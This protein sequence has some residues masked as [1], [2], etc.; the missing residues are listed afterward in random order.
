M[1]WIFWLSLGLC[2]TSCTT[3]KLSALSAHYAHGPD[4]FQLKLRSREVMTTTGTGEHVLID[5]DQNSVISPDN[6]F[7][8]R[9]YNSH[10]FLHADVGKKVSSPSFQAIK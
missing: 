1:K 8:T 9:H 5:Y 4:V 3:S 7:F 6:G 2:L 10:F